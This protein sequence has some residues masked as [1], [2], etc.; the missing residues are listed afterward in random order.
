MGFDRARCWVGRTPPSST[1]LPATL[2]TARS[3]RSARPEYLPPTL[4]TTCQH[5][6]RSTFDT[7]PASDPSRSARAAI[8]GGGG[9]TCQSG[10]ATVRCCGRATP[11]VGKSLFGHN[12]FRIPEYPEDARLPINVTP[13]IAIRPRGNQAVLRTFTATPAWPAE[14]TRQSRTLCLLPCKQKHRRRSGD[15]GHPGR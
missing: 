10:A 6:P 15:L 5:R 9:D 11:F 7:T 8:G 3:R 13:S 2:G 1:L 12:S 4:T 14:T